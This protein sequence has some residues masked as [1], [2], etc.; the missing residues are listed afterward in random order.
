[1]PANP[2]LLQI[3]KADCRLERFGML[4]GLQPKIGRLVLRGLFEG[5]I[6]FFLFVSVLLV[7][8]LLAIFSIV[9]A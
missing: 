3:E 8:A 9:V 7:S 4:E 1:M 2:E 6:A 5:K